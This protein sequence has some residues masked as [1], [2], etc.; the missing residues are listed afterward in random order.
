MEI[1]NRKINY[2]SGIPVEASLCRIDR[3]L[4]HFHPHDLE[5]VCC[6]RGEI[7]LAAADQRAVLGPGQIH[8]I[9]YRDI[10]CLY[11]EDEDNLALIF[12]LDLTNIPYDWEQIRYVFFACESNHCYAYQRD[13]MNAVK[14]M[15]LSF[16]YGYITGS[17]TP[18]MY[19]G[20]VE[21]FSFYLLQY[22][23]WFNYENQDEYMNEDLYERFHRVLAYCIDHYDQK[24]SISQ[25]AATEHISKNYFSQFIS[26]TVFRSFSTM[27]KYIRCYEAEHLL[28]TTDKPNAEIAFECGFSDP[29]YFYSAF[30]QL[31]GCTPSEH[32]AR[33]EKYYQECLRHYESSLHAK[34]GDTGSKKNTGDDLPGQQRLADDD[35]AAVLKEYI[36]A[37]HLEKT[38]GPPEDAGRGSEEGAQVI[39]FSLRLQ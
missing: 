31:W 17:Y 37:W 13:A 24:I 22:F 8:S 2:V 33:Y 32:R 1:L 15:I 26:N 18:E 9:D 35:A 30:R 19:A 14:D 6:L 5:I 27:I 28:L 29:K 23:N 25:L 34:A 21:F 3:S 38:F 7:H 10:H 16:S 20:P 36:A 12:H 39:D 4:P 11:A